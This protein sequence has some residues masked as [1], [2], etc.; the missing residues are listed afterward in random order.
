MAINFKELAAKCKNSVSSRAAGI[1]C[2][3]IACVVTVALVLTSLTRVTI[4]DGKL[5][6]DMI[7]A[8]DDTASILASAG[9]SHTESDVVTSV[10]D[11]NNMDISLSRAF[12]VTVSCGDKTYDVMTHGDT[13]K[14]IVDLAGVQLS[15][16]DLV[17]PSLDTNIT[18]TC[19]IDVVDVDY[20]T[21]NKTVG[22]PYTTKT[23]KSSRLMAGTKSVSAGSEGVKVYTYKNKVVDGVVT[24]SVCIGEEIVKEPVEEVITIGTGAPSLSNPKGWVSTLTPKKEILLDGN[25]VPL[26]YV[27]KMTGTATAYHGDPTTATGVKPQPGHI[28]VNPKVI[29]YGTKMYIRST[30][31]KYIYGYAVAVDTGGACMKNKIIADLYFPTEESMNKFGRREIEI[32]ILE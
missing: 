26:N 6:F 28:A 22:I 9:I 30:D 2:L 25:G 5:R 15:E 19:F 18:S 7:S 10:K 24:E 8:H 16:H 20:T 27:K 32:Y 17:S 31:G 13:V 14:N 21:S 12:K 29:P 4:I 1:V 3:G 23:V 11:G